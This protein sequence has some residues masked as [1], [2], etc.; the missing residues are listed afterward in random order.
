MKYSS[1]KLT[2]VMAMTGDLLNEDQSNRKE[3]R[4]NNI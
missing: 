3:I 2:E 1:D 4:F